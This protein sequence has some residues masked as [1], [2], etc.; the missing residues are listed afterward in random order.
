[1]KK[2]LVLLV[3]VF[4]LFGTALADAQ[5][6]RSSF[7]ELPAECKIRPL[8]RVFPNGK[9][10]A[11]DNAVL[12]FRGTWMDEKKPFDPRWPNVSY[13]TCIKRQNNCHVVTAYVSS[14]ILDAMEFDYTIRLWR[15][16]VI[17]ASN[18]GLWDYA[19]G[20]TLIIRSSDKSIV[21]DRGSQ[22]REI[23]GDGS[24]LTNKSLEKF[25]GME[26]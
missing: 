17:I 11:D 2:L 4:L 25:Y 24:P 14:D 9:F 8:I 3:A 1:M 15:P 23:L 5:M 13:I 6:V 7:S 10:P 16:E 21:L 20:T 18:E 19:E 22:G 26:K 12:I